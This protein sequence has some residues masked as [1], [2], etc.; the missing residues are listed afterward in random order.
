MNVITYLFPGQGSQ[1]PGMGQDFYEASPAARTVFDA[2]EHILGPGFIDQ[3]FHGNDEELRDTRL[4]QPALVTVELAIA[5]HLE[6]AGVRPDCVAGHSI[7][8]IA[9]L[10]A[11]GCIDTEEAIR[12]AEE[13]GSAMAEESPAGAMA[14]IMGMDIKAIELVLPAD[15]E[16]ANYNGPAQTIISGSEQAIETARET[17]EHCGARRLI[18]LNVS[19]PFHCSLMKPAADRFRKVISSLKIAAP[20][21]SFLSSVSGKEEHDP[22]RI[23]ELLATQIESAVRWTDVMSCVRTGEVLETGPGAVLQ[24]IARRIDGSLAVIP[25][26]NFAQAQAWIGTRKAELA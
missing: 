3:I 4:T 25:V 19:G 9:A 8:E 21:C 7:G 10:A 14:A 20:R 12:L 26:G 5:A 13:R 18:R 15:V 6:S 2:A 22:A 24:G 23:H 1:K 11:A 17:L 16:I